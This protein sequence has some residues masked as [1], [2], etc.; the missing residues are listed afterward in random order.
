MSEK[1]TAAWAPADADSSIAARSIAA[2]YP[3]RRNSG[4]VKTAPTPSTR[5]GRPA[6]VARRSYVF[7]AEVS[8]P[9]ANHPRSR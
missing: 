2:A 3:R 8:L 5:S 1:S 9:F 6:Q 7:I 4:G